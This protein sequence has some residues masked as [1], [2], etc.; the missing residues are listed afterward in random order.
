MSP[1]GTRGGEG[2]GG[3]GG[4]GAIAPPPLFKEF[5]L[6]NFALNGRECL[7]IFPG[8]KPSDPTSEHKISQF[9]VLCGIATKT[10]DSSIFLV[11]WD[12]LF[13][14]NSRNRSGGFAPRLPQ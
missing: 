10:C 1:G 5:P 7:K 3:G 12:T 11:F 9:A 8:E 13:F 2:G 6:K 14:C 4:G